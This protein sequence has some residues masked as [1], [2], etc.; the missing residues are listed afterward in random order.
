MSDEIL[1]VDLGGT[2]FRMAKVSS[3]GV[4][5]ARAEIP[6]ASITDVVDGLG[7]LVDQVDGGG[8]A[9]LVFAAPGV[10]D[11]DAGTVVFCGNLD[12]AVRRTIVASRI[13]DALAKRVV[14]VNDADAAAI[15]EAWAGAGRGARTV[16]YVTVS[17]GIGAGL[18]H[19]GTLYVGRF[20]GMEAG[21]IRLGLEDVDRA[22]HVGSGTALARTARQ[23]GLEL[24]NPEVVRRAHQE[25]VARLALTRTM[26]ALGVTLA[27]L[28]WLLV[29]D[30]IVIGGGLG[31]SDPL[32]LELATQ[33]FHR[34]GPAFLEDLSIVP[35][36]LGD[37]AGL[38]GAAFAERALQGA[39]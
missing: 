3:E 26:E 7:R 1:A 11:R 25:G 13:A 38:I 15:G 20:T 27:N 8:V 35:A 19:R 5:L 24:A 9:T 31:L 14:L 12:D 34:A 28:A 18:V 39:Q 33:A 23:L 21:Q 30:R 22:E 36:A 4:L 17:T 37:D 32:V 29:P 10:V 2:N 6:T 16:V